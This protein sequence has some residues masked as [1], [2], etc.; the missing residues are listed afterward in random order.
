MI[1]ASRAASSAS[2]SS[3]RSSVRG[4]RSPAL[5]V[6][7]QQVVAVARRLAREGAVVEA[8]QADDP[9]RDRAHRHERAD[10]QV[11]AA[12]VG[13]GRAALEPV[14]EQRPQLGQGQ[15]RALPASALADRSPPA[16]RSSWLRCQASCAGGGGERVGGRR[17]RRCPAGHALRSGERSQGRVEP[18]DELGEA[19]RELDLAALDLGDRQHPDQQRAVLG[20]IVTPSSSRFEPGRPGAGV[21]L[22][23]L[24][25]RRGRRRRG[26]SGCRCSQ[27]SRGSAPG[28]RR[29]SRS[30]RAR[31]RC[32]PGRAPRRR[33]RGSMASSSSRASTPSIGFVCRSERSASRTRRAGGSPTAR[34]SALAPQT[35]PA[36]AER[37]LDQR[38]ERLDVRA[39]HDHVT[40]LERRVVGQPVEDRLAQDLDLAGA[41]VAGVD[42]DAVV[43]AAELRAGVL[44]AVGSGAP[45]G[46]RSARMSDCSASSS[47][48]RRS[49]AGS[50]WWISVPIPLTRV[51]RPRTSRPR[52]RA[53]GSGARRCPT[54]PARGAAASGA[55]RGRSP[56]PRGPAGGWRADA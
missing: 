27:P 13:P 46:W 5:R 28:R 38:R 56:G 39:H 19:A 21:D 14:P 37:R 11:A 52:R 44:V 40:W 36:A 23:E 25:G 29:R 51:W 8:E 30:V 15:A 12:E 17:Q 47:V 32:R 34:S 35:R 53:D 4:S 16:V 26:P 3:W 41:A 49:G 7:E 42:L 6:G 1:R 20:V 22:A 24:V 43:V 55:R 33:S 54:S 48:S 2:S 45:G 10:G 18:V 31:A 9:V 50:G